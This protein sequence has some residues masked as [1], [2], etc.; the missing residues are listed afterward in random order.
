MKKKNS[1]ILR[2]KALKKQ[3]FDLIT[4]NLLDKISNAF[5]VFILISWFGL[6]G[7]GIWS[8]LFSILLIVDSLLSFGVSNYAL[9]FFVQNR[10]K[11]KKGIANLS[12]II[13]VIKITFLI[14]FIF[15]FDT[16]YINQIGGKITL[17]NLSIFL[18][19]QEAAKTFQ[20]FIHFNGITYIIL[21]SRSVQSIF[22]TITLF[23]SYIF[24]LPYYFASLSYLTSVILCFSTLYYFWKTE[25]FRYQSK[26]IKKLFFKEFMF[27]LIKVFKGSIPF[28]VSSL[29]VLLYLKSDIVCLKFFSIEDSLIG[30]YSLAS[31]IAAAFYF[32]PINAYKVLLGSFQGNN[33]NEILKKFKTKILITCLS[34]LISQEVL[35]FLIRFLHNEFLLFPKIIYELASLLSILCIGL[36]GVWLIEYGALFFAANNKNWLLNS[37]SLITFINNISLNLILIPQYGIY[38]AAIGTTAALI[39]TGGI[40]LCLKK[41]IQQRILNKI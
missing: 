30:K 10:F 16:S 33:I 25:L 37:R 35:Y 22:R 6:S 7:F 27:S 3:F 28:T 24:S 5:N 38:G 1:L 8:V 34:I 14:F 21:I 41:N 9:E 18:I 26:Q 20:S 13:I 17:I 12:L 40:V 23:L 29:T 4:S 31:T 15:L 19:I 11:S 2:R 36:L 32:I 39:V